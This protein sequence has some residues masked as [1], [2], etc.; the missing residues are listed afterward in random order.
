VCLALIKAKILF[1]RKNRKIQY[2]SFLKQK[3]SIQIF[4]IKII[5]ASE[6]YYFLMKKYICVFYSTVQSACL[7]DKPRGL[8]ELQFPDRLPGELFDADTQCR[9][10]F[11][12]HARLC[13]FDFG[14][15]KS[16]IERYFYK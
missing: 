16:V 13:I 1:S 11:G 2:F 15:V 4:D 7:E 8:G 6:Q 3:K 9:W 12:R 5:K 14:K 10:Q